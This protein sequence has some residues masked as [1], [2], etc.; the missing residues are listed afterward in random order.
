MGLISLKLKSMSADKQEQ[1]M[2]SLQRHLRW[3]VFVFVIWWIMQ[4][5]SNNVSAS[6]LEQIKSIVYIMIVDGSLD[7]LINYRTRIGRQSKIFLHLN[8]IILTTLFRSNWC[9]LGGKDN[10]RRG[11]DGNM[12]WL[13]PVYFSIHWIWSTTWTSWVLNALQW[14]LMECI[15]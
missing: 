7:E 6:L 13:A 14:M 9:W 2:L 15:L 1:Q 4:D 10:S 11:G 8:V 3:W 5:C 12:H